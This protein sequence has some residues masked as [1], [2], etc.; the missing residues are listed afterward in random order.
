MLASDSFPK[1]IS[2]GINAAITMAVVAVLEISIDA[3][4]VTIIIPNKIQRGLLLHILKVIRIRSASSRVFVMAA[5]RK[6][7]PSISQI[8]LL[9][10]VLV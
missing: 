5:A 2:K 1:R 6:N 9:E 8:T 10:N 4:I 3:T 7:P